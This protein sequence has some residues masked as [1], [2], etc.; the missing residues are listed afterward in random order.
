MNVTTRYE[1]WNR[2]RL[3][4]ADNSE[5]AE[6]FYGS[7]HRKTDNVRIRPIDPLDDLDA[8]TLRGV[9]ARFVEGIYLT[10]VCSDLGIVQRAKFDMRQL[11]HDPFA[12]R[13][14]Y[15]Y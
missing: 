13:V 2:N 5:L 1:L 8:V 12:R 7:F 4:R 14:A 15:E 6:Q 11:G 10:K 9:S 3:K